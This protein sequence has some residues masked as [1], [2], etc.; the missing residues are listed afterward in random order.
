[1]IYEMRCPSCGELIRYFPESVGATFIC[2]KCRKTV[3][4]VQVSETE[5]E[6]CPNGQQV[7]GVSGRR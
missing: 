2:P 3:K 6:S 5:K 7:E 1:M 4:L